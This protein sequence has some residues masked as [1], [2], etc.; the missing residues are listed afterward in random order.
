MEK[1]KVLF[2]IIFIV[3]LFTTS[4]L[5]IGKLVKGTV[6]IGLLHLYAVYFAIFYKFNLIYLTLISLHIVVCLLLAYF[7]T[8]LLT[9]NNPS[10]SKG[11]V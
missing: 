3:I 9:K 11:A 8:K 7:L 4:L 1:K 6:T 10:Q 5:P 2:W